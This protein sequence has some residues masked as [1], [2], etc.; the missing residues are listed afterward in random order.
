MDGRGFVKLL[1]DTHVLFWW[2]VAPAA[3][4]DPARKAIEEA[5]TVFVSAA[6]A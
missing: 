3:V 1:L 4:W 2:V 6:S 5:E